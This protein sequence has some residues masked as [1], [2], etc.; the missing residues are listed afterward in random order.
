MNTTKA[1]MVIAPYW[2]SGTWVFDDLAVGLVREPFAERIEAWVDGVLAAAG[3]SLA[4]EEG[5]VTQ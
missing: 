5:A 3:R 1:L 2:W 4:P